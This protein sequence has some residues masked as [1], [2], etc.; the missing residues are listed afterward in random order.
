MNRLKRLKIALLAT[1]VLV[2]A[3]T[4]ADPATEKRAEGS[5]A[6]SAVPTRKEPLRLVPQ[7]EGTPLPPRDPSVA[8]SWP[9]EIKQLIDNMLALFPKTPDERPPSVKEVEQK[10]GI[11]L[12]ER[13]LKPQEM[14]FYS[15]QFVISGTRYINPELHR[16]GLGDRYSILRTSPPGESSQALTLVISPK[17]SGFCLNPYELAVYTGSKFMNADMSPHAVIRRWPPAYVWGMF[18]WSNT[19]YYHGQGFH[20]ILGQDRDITTEKIISAGCVSQ[21]GVFGRY[22]E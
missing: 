21:I 12:T 16:F 20:V 7:P 13:P 18:S 5:T 22:Q 15:R 17:Q 4:T 10:M 2:S 3:C 9:P 1:T 8:D 19:G 6:D 14:N 11:R